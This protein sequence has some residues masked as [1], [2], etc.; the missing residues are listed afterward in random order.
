[1]DIYDGQ[2]EGHPTNAGF[3]RIDHLTGVESNIRRRPTHIETN[4]AIHTGLLRH[5][6]SA[7][8]AASRAAQDGAGRFIPGCLRRNHPAVRLHNHQPPS[9][10]ASFDAPKVAIHQRGNIGI[11]NSGTGPFKLS[12]LRQNIGRK[13]ERHV[14]TEPLLHLLFDALFVSRMQKGK[15]QAD[16]HRF[17]SALF[18]GIQGTIN[19][20]FVQWDKYSLWSHALYDL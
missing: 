11:D 8:R 19:A 18:D 15:E 6:E 1:M 10:Q 3:S 5:M 2:P 20:G 14:V 7:N 12:V 17:D 9:S 16:R 4:N 13:R